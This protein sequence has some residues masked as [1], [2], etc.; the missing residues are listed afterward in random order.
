MKHC[1]TTSEIN[2]N[3]DPRAKGKE[4]SRT[5][6]EMLEPEFQDRKVL[7]LNIPR[8]EIAY[9]EKCCRSL[10][11]SRSELLTYLLDQ[12][13]ETSR[14]AMWKGVEDG[15]FTMNELIHPQVRGRRPLEADSVEER[16]KKRK[17]KDFMSWE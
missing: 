17:L 4:M 16:E 14:D 6:R 11:M 5:M 15:R 9:Y 7:Q 2:T 8:V 3:G 13:K 1:T 12:V 10:G